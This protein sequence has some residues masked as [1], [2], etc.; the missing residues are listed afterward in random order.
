[1]ERCTMTQAQC[2]YAIRGQRADLQE[3]HTGLPE[4][5]E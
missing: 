2:D 5:V 1:M 4:K 3:R